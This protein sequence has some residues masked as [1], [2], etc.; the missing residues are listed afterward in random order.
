MLL[1]ID[2]DVTINRIFKYIL[3]HNVTINR[4]LVHNV[5]LIDYNSS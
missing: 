3:Y 5:L 4:L 2:Q 1:L